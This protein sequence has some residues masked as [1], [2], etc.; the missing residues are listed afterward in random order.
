MP[1]YPG[2]DGYTDGMVSMNGRGME[3]LSG[4][5]DE[6]FQIL[7]IRLMRQV[8]GFGFRIIGGREEGS[9]ATIGAIVSG[10]AADLDGR[11]LIGDEITHINGRSVLDASHRDVISLMGEAAA[12]V[13]TWM[14]FLLR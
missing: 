6:P 10:G 12:Q 9:Q 3:E 14:L 11:L 4:G 2:P 8:S 5:E 1:S 13:H 7:E